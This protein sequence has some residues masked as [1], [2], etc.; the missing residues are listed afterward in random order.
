MKRVLCLLVLAFTIYSCGQGEQQAADYLELHRDA[1]VI[2]LH[3]D[4]VLRMMEGA[5]FGARDTTGHMDIPRLQD[6]GID[7]QVIACWL[8]TEMPLEEC[9]LHADI[10]ID[11]VNAQVAR[12]SDQVEICR[13]AAEAER[14]GGDGKIAIFIGLENGVAIAN[15]LDNIQRFFDTWRAVFDSLSHRFQRLVYFIG[16]YAFCFRRLNRFWS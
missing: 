13:T 8:P 1:L 7:L 3:S 11:S 15:D 4:V 5:D 16:R 14:V 2:D 9:R 12:N 6:G 10:I